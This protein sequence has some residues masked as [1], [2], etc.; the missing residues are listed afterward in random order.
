MGVA[1]LL[2][3][4]AADADVTAGPSAMISAVKPA[5]VFRTHADPSNSLNPILLLSFVPPELSLNLFGAPK[6]GEI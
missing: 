3:F 4:G 6:E 1:V 2:K 5:T